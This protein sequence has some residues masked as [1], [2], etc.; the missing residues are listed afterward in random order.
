[1]NYIVCKNKEQFESI[2]DY[3][4]CSLEDMILPDVIACDSETTG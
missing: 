1:M 3:N 4:Y 2:G